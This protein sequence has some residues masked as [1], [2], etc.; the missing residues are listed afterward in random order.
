MNDD[1]FGLNHHDRLKS[2]SLNIK[3]LHCDWMNRNFPQTIYF[4]DYHYNKTL[5]KSPFSSHICKAYP[6]SLGQLTNLPIFAVKKKRDKIHDL[7]SFLFI[8]LE[9]KSS[10]Q[11]IKKS[12]DNRDIGAKFLY[13][14]GLISQHLYSRSSY[15]HHKHNS[16]ISWSEKTN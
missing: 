11:R 14:L 1:Q 5:E 10:D 12:R 16:I 8:S 6:R 4:L 3:F 2:P 13:K 15:I 7:V 9:R